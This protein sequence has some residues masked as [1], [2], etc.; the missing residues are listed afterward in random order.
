MRSQPTLAALLL[1]APLALAQPVPSQ[2]PVVLVQPPASQS[3]PVGILAQRRSPLQIDRAEDHL[4]PDHPLLS[5]QFRRLEAPPLL[6]VRITAHGSTGSSRLLPAAHSS[7]T[8]ASETFHLERTAGATDL[9]R[10]TLDPHRLSSFSWIEVTELR[11]ADGTAWHP[12]AASRCVA[13]PNGFLLI[14]NP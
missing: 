11:Y 4:A 8:D 12:S 14:A 10:G 2:A 13:E 5:V 3:C 1:S 6:A 7:A 9:R